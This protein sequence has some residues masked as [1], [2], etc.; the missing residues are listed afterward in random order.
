M[1]YDALMTW[2][3]GLLSS[4]LVLGC[5]GGLP[6]LGSD[7]STSDAASVVMTDTGSSKDS[8]ASDSGSCQTTPPSNTC[9]LSPQC[10]CPSGQTC[11]VDYPSHTDGTAHCV[12]S[13]GTGAPMS[14]CGTT[15]D[16]AVGLS[17][18]GEVC[19]PYCSNLGVGCGGGLGACEQFGT[20][21]GTA[22]ANASVCAINC[23]LDDLYACGGGSAGCVWNSPTETDCRDLTPYNSYSCTAQKPFCLPGYACLAD[24][25]C[26]LW[27][28]VALDNCGA[29]QC[30]PFNTPFLVQGIEYGVCQ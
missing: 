18:W 25:T 23:K 24:D 22:I 6:S 27:C 21:D 1:R 12:T 20:D 14:H 2:G 29:Y 28:E 7:A 3:W 5:S 10:G 16:C 9:G 8:S 4:V 30:T 17:C 11:D 15:Q 19:R 13:T 26:A